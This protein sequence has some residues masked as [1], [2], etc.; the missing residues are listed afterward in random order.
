MPTNIEYSNWKANLA[1][2]AVRNHL[3][4]TRLEVLGPDRSIDSDFWLEDGLL[5]SGIDLDSD[6]QRGPFVE[7]MLRA[8]KTALTNHMTHSV[9][10]VKRIAL[11][12]GDSQDE[13]L[14]IEDTKGTVTIMHFESEVTN[15]D[16]SA[17]K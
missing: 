1:A 14:V 9:A 11:N 8:S 6:G 4:P 2:F 12:T 17:R 7:I 5:L 15:G 13:G 16:Q 10:G 3:R